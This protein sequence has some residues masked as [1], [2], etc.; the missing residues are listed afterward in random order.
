MFTRMIVGLRRAYQGQ[1]E[2][3]D[4]RLSF[5]I[6]PRLW[7]VLLILALPFFSICADY[8]EALERTGALGAFI[9]DSLLPASVL[10][11]IVLVFVFKKR[12]I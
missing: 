8:F 2:G 5:G 9:A 11:Y 3:G 12:K 7:M 1:A 6:M 10:G 4:L